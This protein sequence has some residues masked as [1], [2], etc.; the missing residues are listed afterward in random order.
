MTFAEWEVGTVTDVQAL[1]TLTSDLGEVE[2]ELAP[3][4]AQRS[5]LRDQIARIVAHAGNKVELTGFGTLV[6]TQPGITTSY[7]AKA[8]DALVI[9]LMGDGYG[10]IAEQIAQCRRESAR[11]GSLRITREKG[12]H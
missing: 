6:I 3:L 8:L 1:H 11:A 9:R 5:A 4:E 7:D 10:P 12:S 2:S